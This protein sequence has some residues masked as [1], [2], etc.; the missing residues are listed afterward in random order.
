MED[1]ATL[2]RQGAR[3]MR[4]DKQI[5]ISCFQQ[6]LS[7]PYKREDSN[8]SDEKIYCVMATCYFIWEDYISAYKYYLKS[9]PAL[10]ANQGIDITNKLLW[11]EDYYKSSLINNDEKQLFESIADS[12]YVKLHQK[13]CEIEKQKRLD[14]FT[15]SLDHSLNFDGTPR[16]PDTYYSRESKCAILKAVLYVINAD[17]KITKAEEEYFIK[18]AMTFHS[19]TSIMD[20]AIKMS[21][22]E[23]L[24]QLDK[25]DRKLLCKYLDEAAQADGEVT[26]EE[27]NTICDIIDSTPSCQA[28]SLK[29]RK[30]FKNYII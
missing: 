20:D 1:R 8:Y 28:E 9:I 19:E 27:M 23:M 16:F 12:K 21:D 2:W 22:K 17:G 3:I 24:N 25:I 10:R 30:L 29:Y 26:N 15:K 5:A 4:S 18:L 14:A 6:A 13:R 7:I 11:I